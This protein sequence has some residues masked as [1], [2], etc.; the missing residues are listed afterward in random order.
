VPTWD[1]TDTSN[2]MLDAD[3]RGKEARNLIVY[4][5]HAHAFTPLS[6]IPEDQAEKDCSGCCAWFR[7]YL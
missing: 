7:I 4:P 5:R 1:P 3:A 2:K 6:P